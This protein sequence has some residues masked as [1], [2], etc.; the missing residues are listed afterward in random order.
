MPGL[1]FTLAAGSVESFSLEITGLGDE[2]TEG[3]TEWIAAG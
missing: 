1:E 2:S 3:E